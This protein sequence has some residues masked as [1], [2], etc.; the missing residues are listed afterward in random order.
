MDLPMRFFIESSSSTLVHCIS[1]HFLKSRKKW[2]NSTSVTTACDTNES[3]SSLSKAFDGGLDHVHTFYGHF[4][5]YC[6]L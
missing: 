5:V 4:I 3:F 2:K 1:T 6:I